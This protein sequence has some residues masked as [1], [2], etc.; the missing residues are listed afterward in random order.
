LFELL[1]EWGLNQ[2]DDLKIQDTLI[3][4]PSEHMNDYKEFIKMFKKDDNNESRQKFLDIKK[5]E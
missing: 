1:N 5:E 2:A 3:P 4:I